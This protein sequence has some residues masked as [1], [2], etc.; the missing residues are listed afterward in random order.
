MS[1]R[2]VWGRLH[3]LKTRIGTTWTGTQQLTINNT[4]IIDKDHNQDITFMVY[5]YNIRIR[6]LVIWNDIFCNLSF[7]VVFSQARLFIIS[8]LLLLY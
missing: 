3:R 1:I 6:K 2:D 8:S 7:L 5:S 4:F